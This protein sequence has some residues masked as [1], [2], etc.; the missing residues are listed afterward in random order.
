[1][2]LTVLLALCL[3]SALASADMRATDGGSILTLTDPQSG[4]RLGPVRV[5]LVRDGRA[6]P[7]GQVRLIQKPGQGHLRI[8]I[9]PVGAPADEIRL[10][11]PADSDESFFGGGEVWNGSLNQRGK[12]LEMW[13]GEGT[14]DRCCYVPFYLSTRGY[15][16][17]VE[18]C[19]RGT[20]AFSTPENPDS[21]EV[22]FRTRDKQGLTVYFI[23]G[24]SPKSVLTNYTAVT[25]RPPL[26]PKW[27]FIPWKWRDEHKG[28]DQVF[29]DAEGMRKHDIPC[30]VQ[31]I[32]NP[33]Q[34]HGL[35]SFEFDPVRFP[36]AP[37]RIRRLKAMDYKIVVWVAPF[38]NPRVPNYQ[39]ALQRG[40]FVRNPKGE[41]YHMG[42]GYYID[43]T[44]PAAYDWWKREM[45]KVIALG[46]DGFKLDR[47]QKIPDDAVFSDGSTGA[48]MHNRYALLY[49]KVCH[50][51]LDEVLHGDFTMLPRPGA[52]GSQVYSPGKWPGDL[53]SDL[54]PKS[55]LPSAIIAGQSIA[56]S[57]FPFWGSDTGGFE[58]GGPDKRT[59]LRWA[60]FSCFSPIMQLG[61]KDSH[62]PWDPKFAPEGLPVYRYYATLH[63]ELLPY[64]YTYATVA[65]ETGLP[66]MRPLVLEY[67][68]DPAAHSQDFEF[69][70]GEHILT[71]P[72]YSQEDSREVYLP[73]GE[74]IDY[75][76]WNRALRGP[77]T[78]DV[79][80]TLDRMPVYLRNGA[81]IPMKVA[82]SVTGHGGDYSA[83]RL[84]VLVLPS[85]RSHF[86]IR[87]GRLT[88]DFWCA[89]Q[90]RTTKVAWKNASKALLLRVRTQ[91]PAAVSGTKAYSRIA[92][93]A[94]YSGRPG[95][96]CYDAARMCAMISPWRDDTH[97]IL[98]L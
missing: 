75:W 47:G 88:T 52:A 79:R 70:Y 28:W 12:K 3:L 64:T 78:L 36:D 91:N 8:E 98:S 54:S 89:R 67:P 87:D 29:E 83:D 10:T 6:D 23:S 84:T 90:D 74:W 58:R 31:W 34:E 20:F 62:E 45:R 51:A 81:I 44:N 61:G 60:Q 69:L 5:G 86:A 80:C 7:D 59:L 17:Y 65:H 71:A 76:D 66:I 16:L 68:N 49:C 42:E 25:G 19:E 92:D 97:V 11:I 1:M 33:W 37:E 21:V 9:S 14:P 53:S 56:L 39:V 96:W 95:T 35:C 48:S 2:Y 13:V 94:N 46:I 43:F 73:K 72:L 93:P 40:Y 22:T 41:P 4:L 38:T 57:G 15:G 77:A 30:S 55:G 26:P 82:N 18:S 24:P 27:S 50:E 32:D 85:G 63:A